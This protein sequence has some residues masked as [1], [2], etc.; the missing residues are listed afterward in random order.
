MFDWRI[1]QLKEFEYA[2]GIDLGGTKIAACLM[3]E[4]GGIWKS[5]TVPTMAEE[6]AKAVM[7]RIKGCICELTK[8]ANPT[9][10]IAAGIVVPGVIDAERRVVKHLPNLPGWEDVPLP[11]IIQNMLQLPVAMENDANAAALGEYLYGSGRGTDN[12]MYITI[13][14]GIGSG[15]V[16][17]GKLFRGEWGNAG[18]IGHITINH[19]GP[20]CS[21]GSYG[22]WEAYASGTALARFAREGILN[23]R[24]TI[25]KDMAPNEIKAENIFD[26][27]K[28]GDKFALELVEKEGFYLG[29]GLAN[30]VNAFNPGLIVIGGGLSNEWEMFYNK[31]INTMKI[32]AFKTNT[33]KLKIVKTSLGSK[34]G[35]IG[36]AAVGWRL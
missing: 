34:V 33:E 29:A 13:S 11:E 23:G 21:C 26:A 28:K 7:E 27:A 3:K 31:M 32:R 1:H 10:I 15:I 16:L 17:D 4:D 12:F 5:I 35:M 9:E 18:E 2:L 19:E 24:E 6:G 36:A 8:H 14:T 20:K 30:V 22:C 25:I